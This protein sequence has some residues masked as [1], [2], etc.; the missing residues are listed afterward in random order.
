MFPS[1]R[2]G[3]CDV[4][5]KHAMWFK[6]IPAAAR[7]GFGARPQSLA[8]CGETHVLFNF[9]REFFARVWRPHFL[10]LR[11]ITSRCNEEP[12]RV[13][14]QLLAQRLLRT[15]RCQ[16]QCCARSVLGMS[17]EFRSQRQLRISLPT[18][19][20]CSSF[21]IVLMRIAHHLYT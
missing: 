9:R 10:K 4:A 18:F 21:A 13:S 14:A 20:S 2:Y 8:P 15:S 5:K 1:I 19:V 12:H 11:E 7:P 6:L 17:L 16:L 3:F